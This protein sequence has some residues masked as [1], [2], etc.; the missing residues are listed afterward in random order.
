MDRLFAPDSENRWMNPD[1]KLYSTRI[2]IDGIRDWVKPGMSAKIEIQV[3][4]LEDV[5][6]VPLQAVSSREGKQ[7][8]F[9]PGRKPTPVGVNC[10]ASPS[11]AGR[12][13]WAGPSGERSVR[14]PSGVNP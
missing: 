11:A 7:V 1:M 3:K 14:H 2:A 5:V 12:A 8:V 10:A 13:W 4:R 6:Y 9:R